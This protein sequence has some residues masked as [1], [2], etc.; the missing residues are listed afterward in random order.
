MKL[1]TAFHPKTDGQ[2]ERIIQTPEDMLRACVI[3]LKKSLD[4]HLPLINFSYNNSYDP[5]IFMEPFEELY[6]WR[7]RSPIG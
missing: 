3:D 6:G 2:V 4:D 1:R 7:F 5:S